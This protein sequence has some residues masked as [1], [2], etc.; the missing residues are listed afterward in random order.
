M[1]AMNREIGQL[2]QMP[3]EEVTGFCKANGIPYELALK[4]K[5][6]GRLPVVNFAAGGIATPADVALMMRTRLRWSFCR[7]RD[8]QVGPI[9]PEGAGYC[10]GDCL[11][12][13]SAKSSGSVHGSG[14]S[15]AGPGNFADSAGTDSRRARLVNL[16]VTAF[17]ER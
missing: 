5:E 1:R 17:S 13:R 3:V 7:F 2:V 6:L 12:Q 4:V 14:R 15:H 8:I 11:F 16:Y 10:Q 9:R